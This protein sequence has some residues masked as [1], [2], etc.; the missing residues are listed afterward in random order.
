VFL[1]ETGAIIIVYGFSGK[2]RLKSMQ[3]ASLW[4]FT[5][6]TER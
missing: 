6:E 4:C 2:K 3:A 5:D 1:T